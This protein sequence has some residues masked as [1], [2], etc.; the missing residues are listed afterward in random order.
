MFY[1]GVNADKP[2]YSDRNVVLYTAF[3]CSVYAIFR[4]KESMQ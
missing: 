4:K 2:H 3:D 1:E